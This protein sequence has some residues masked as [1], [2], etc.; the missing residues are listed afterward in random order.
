MVTSTVVACLE[1]IDIVE[2]FSVWVGFVS[3]ISVVAEMIFDESV[4]G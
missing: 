2:N 3:D 4:V 1:R